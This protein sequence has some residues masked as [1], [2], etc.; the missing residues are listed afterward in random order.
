MS[1]RKTNKPP[2]SQ[3]SKIG[4]RAVAKSV[5]FRSAPIPTVEELQG[6]ENIQE[7]LAS[8]I[9]AMAENQQKN[10]QKIELQ[11]SESFQKCQEKL[12]TGAVTYRIL[13]QVIGGIVVLSALIGGIY[14]LS[15]GRNLAGYVTMLGA[16][17]GLAI[18]VGLRNKDENKNQ[19]EEE[20]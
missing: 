10:R 5:S 6:Y 13:G 20:Q 8:R 16:I 12:V 2:V 3:T 14:L 17:G 1:K 4:T 15:I 9:V 7:G 19:S 11:E 18:S